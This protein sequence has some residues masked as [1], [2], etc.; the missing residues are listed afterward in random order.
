MSNKNAVVLGAGFAGLLTA[1]VL[2]KLYQQVTVVDWDPAP[3]Q[4]RRGVPHG[5]HAHNLLPAGAS[6]VEEIFPCLVDE[7]SADGAVLADVLSDYRF[8]AGG[9][10]LPRVPVGAHSIHA[11]RPFYERHLRR[12]LVAHEG[13]RMVLGADVAGLIGD[14]RRITGVRILP[15]EPRGNEEILNADL[16]VDAMGRGSRTPVWLE[17]LG[18][19]RPA[20]QRVHVDVAYASRVVRLPPQHDRALLIGGDVKANG[21]G[22]LLLAVE[23]GQHVL[24]VTGVGPAARPPTDEVG[25]AAFVAA[26]APDDVA[27]A[28][29]AADTLS[30]IVA[31]RF[32]ST[33][34]RR[35]DQLSSFPDGLVVVGDALCSL[36]PVNAQGLTVAALEARALRDTLSASRRDVAA[37]YFARA[38]QIL[39]AP[40]GM[41]GEPGQ[42][43]NLTQKM[44]GA[45]MSR[46]MAAAATDRTV[47]A[48]LIRVLALI[49][50]P[51]KLL[52]PAVLGRA[53]FR[54]A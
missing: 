33:R 17:Q 49:D 29:K 50:P 18:Y 43:T 28:L 13:L 30:D 3:G 46:L 31:Y 20:E 19:E 40:W 37:N 6:V 16:V 5:W 53:L 54:A 1:G 2:A 52:R 48:Q 45:M 15:Q 32:P 47:A 8:Y 38:T 22:L 27:S 7:M 41:V 35:Y 9:R 34:W 12:R 44:Q 25:F 24:T 14:D 23:D 36:S 11:T 21:R 26:A 51:S 10:E 4:Y 42:P 39:A